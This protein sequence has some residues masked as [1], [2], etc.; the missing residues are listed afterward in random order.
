M[1]DTLQVFKHIWAV[2]DDGELDIH[3]RNFLCVV[4]VDLVVGVVVVVL[5]SSPLFLSSHPVTTMS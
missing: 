2:G 3:I 1:M 5:L 4:G